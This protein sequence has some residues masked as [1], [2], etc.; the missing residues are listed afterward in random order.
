MTYS[1]MQGFWEVFTFWGEWGGERSGLGSS[2]GVANYC[3]FFF[4][5]GGGGGLTL[6]IPLYVHPIKIVF[7]FLQAHGGD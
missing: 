3:S 4:S 7:I 2:L 1:C 5:A 6:Y